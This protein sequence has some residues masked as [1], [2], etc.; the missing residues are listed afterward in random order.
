MHGRLIVYLAIDVL[1]Q[2]LLT[3]RCTAVAVSVKDL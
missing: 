3:K 1:A 2:I